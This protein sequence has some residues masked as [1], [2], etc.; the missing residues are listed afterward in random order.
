MEDQAEIMLCDPSK[1]L[2]IQETIK[3]QIEKFSNINY[4][5][6]SKGWRL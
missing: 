4:E 5:K 6:T 1:F 2:Q 3:N